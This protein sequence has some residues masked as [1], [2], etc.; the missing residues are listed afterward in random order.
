MGV[1][2]ERILDG[3]E[4]PFEKIHSELPPPPAK[5]FEADGA[6]GFF[7]HMRTNDAFRAVNRLLAAGEEVRRLK[8]PFVAEG[9]TYPPG[10][11]FI[12][13]KDT[14]LPVLEKIAAEIG[15]RFRGSRIAPTTEAVALKRARIALWDRYG[16]SMPSGWTRWVLERFE[17]PFTIV[18]PPD[19][20]RGGL[21]DKFD[22]VILVDG[23]FAVR[24][25]GSIRPEAIGGDQPPPEPT[26]PGSEPNVPEEYRGRRGAIT[27]AKTVPQ[28]RKF[29]EDGGT[30]LTIG[31]STALANPLGIA[32]ANHLVEKDKDGKEQPLRREKFYVPGS[33]LRVRLDEKH[34][35]CWGMAGE[36]DV[37][38]STSPIFRLPD[39]SNGIHRVGW[40]DSKTPLRSGWAWGQEHLDGGV[41]IVD[42]EVGKGRLV[43]FGPQ[44]L[45]RGQPHGTFKLLFNG[46]VHAGMAE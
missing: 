28:L 27:T 26:E 44:I 24:G 45:F 33:L 41:A 23:A 34:P 6:V 40:F 31:S 1:K 8:E 9:D 25:P 37:M 11:F 19:L 5:V 2:F 3:F 17:F 32:V 4:G 15:T 10:M 22:V 16:G 13:R 36:A 38:F 20:D 7:L 12:P 35:L 18:Y 14:T 46:I 29:L 21:R 42:A 30:I 39:E 43:M